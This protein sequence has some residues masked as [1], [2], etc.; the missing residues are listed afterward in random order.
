MKVFSAV[1]NFIFVAKNFNEELQFFQNGVLSSVEFGGIIF[2]GFLNSRIRPWIKN[3]S[4]GP[5]SG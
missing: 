4:I 1:M 3:T 5:F 2:A